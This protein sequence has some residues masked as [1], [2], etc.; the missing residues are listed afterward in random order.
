MALRFQQEQERVE[1]VVQEEKQKVEALEKEIIVPKINEEL[2]TTS[3][4]VQG[5]REQLIALREYINESGLT[6]LKD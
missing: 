5:T 1:S 6:L 4:K 2:L 3:F